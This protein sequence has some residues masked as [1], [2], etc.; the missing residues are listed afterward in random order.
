MGEGYDQ[1]TK[2]ARELSQNG[3]N[4]TE[5]E[6]VGDEDVGFR[7]IFRRSGP[8]IGTVRLV[9]DIDQAAL[10]RGARHPLFHARKV[11]YRRCPCRTASRESLVVN[12]GWEAAWPVKGVEVQTFKPSASQGKHQQVTMCD[13]GMND[14]VGFEWGMELALDRVGWR[15]SL[16]C[17]GSTEVAAADPSRTEIRR[18]AIAPSTRSIFSKS[19]P[20]AGRK[21]VY[22]RW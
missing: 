12:L 9:P 8:N 22:V 4:R 13:I 21:G 15:L 6:C 5:S 2:P 1:R 16:A 3:L 20:T 11:N 10:P 18:A 7:E 19:N 17:K 14:S